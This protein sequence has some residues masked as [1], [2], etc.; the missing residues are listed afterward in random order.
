MCLCRIDYNAR[1]PESVHAWKVFREY[2][3][4]SLRNCYSQVADEIQ[5]IGQELTARCTEH[6]ATRGMH[7]PAGFHATGEDYA[8]WLMALQTRNRDKKYARKVREQLD[9]IQCRWYDGTY[10]CP[11]A[12]PLDVTVQP[13][14]HNYIMREVVLTDI[15][16]VGRQRANGRTYRTWV[17]RKM[18]ILP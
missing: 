11:S 3:D 9:V 17:A 5:P 1:I 6:Y 8:A 13:P 4:G 10:R 14:Q 18:R 15:L 7:Y 2:P 16:C 12:S